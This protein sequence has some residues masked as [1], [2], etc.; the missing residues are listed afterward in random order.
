[1]KLKLKM[2]VCLLL[3]LV[4]LFMAKPVIAEPLKISEELPLEKQVELF[5][6]VYGGDAELNKKVIRCESGWDV[7]ADGDGGISLGVA[8]FQ[9]ESF[10]RMSKAFGE[11]L[12]YNSSYDQLKLFVWAMNNGYAREWTAYRAIKNGG[13][14]S[15]YSKQ[16]GR[17]FTVYCK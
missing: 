12:D 5:T 15:F 7:K 17:H 10:N 13:T 9:L 11:K 14:Y 2:L 1:M 8:Q 16:L 4:V 6:L 3:P